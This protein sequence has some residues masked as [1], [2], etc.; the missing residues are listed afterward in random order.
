MENIFIWKSAPGC[1]HFTNK[2]NESNFKIWLEHASVKK[3]RFAM[4]IGVLPGLK[5]DMELVAANGLPAAEMVSRRRAL[6][7][8]IEQQ[9]TG[10]IILTNKWSK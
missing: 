2:I 9:H 7:D 3:I 5:G 1:D 8:A 4:A 6:A 10:R